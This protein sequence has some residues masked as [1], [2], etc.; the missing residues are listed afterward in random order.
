MWS[1]V[2]DLF[3]DVAIR[4]ATNQQQQSL[5]ANMRIRGANPAIEVNASNLTVLLGE[6]TGLPGSNLSSGASFSLRQGTS[7]APTPPPAFFCVSA[8]SNAAVPSSRVSLSATD[9]FMTASNAW[10]EPTVSLQTF[11]GTERA[12]IDRTGL[13]CEALTATRYTN[14]VGDYVTQNA[15]LPPTASALAEAYITLSNMVVTRVAGGTAP[16]PPAGQLINSYISTSTSAA[17]TATALRGAYFGLSNMMATKLAALTN[18][19][20]ALVAA[21]AGNVVSG[22][23]HAISVAAA[24]LWRSR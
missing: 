18:S 16:S 17:P 15:F 3:G 6:A 21:A 20:P 12:R 1:I 13:S 23:S 2:Q 14:L 9:V 22:L 19:V 11:M 8:S 10:Q 5:P 7:M 24:A 4:M